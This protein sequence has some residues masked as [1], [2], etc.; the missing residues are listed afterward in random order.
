MSLNLI[1]VKKGTTQIF[2]DVGEFIPVTVIQAGPCIVTQ[3]KTA[4]TDGYEAVQLGFGEKKQKRTTK[5]LL[6]HLKKAGTTPKRWLRESRIDKADEYKTGQEIRCDIFSEGDFVD[7]TGLTKGRG[8]A[9]GM[10][11]WNF[12]GGPG[13]HG[14]K[15]HR[16]LGSVGHA[17]SPS[18]IFKGKKMPGHYGVERVTT[19]NLK[20]IKVVAEEDLL[21]VRGTV[22]GATGGMVLVRTALKKR[23]KKKQ[24]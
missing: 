18:K 21:L 7:V 1:G 5:P 22:P 14:S 23:S 9:G 15:F 2:N 16:M 4:D 24:K 10:K 12:K 19:E 13:S 11:R 6:G 17:A 3:V 8:F 20:V